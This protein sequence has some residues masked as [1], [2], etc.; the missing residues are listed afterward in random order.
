MWV[1]NPA[2]NQNPASATLLN[3]GVISRLS[4][5][6]RYRFREEGVKDES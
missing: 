4:H 5:G 6:D 1:I 3:R 2:A